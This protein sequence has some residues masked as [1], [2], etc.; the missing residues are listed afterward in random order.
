MLALALRE[1]FSIRSIDLSRNNITQ[2]SYYEL[3]FVFLNKMTFL[4]KLKFAKSKKNSKVRSRPD[5]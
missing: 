1:N 2:K 3:Q 5:Y 4:D